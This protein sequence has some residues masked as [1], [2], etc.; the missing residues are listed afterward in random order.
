MVA[1]EDR[2]VW[3][4]VLLYP[5]VS[6]Y[7][8]VVAD[9]DWA[10]QFGARANDDV[11]ADRRVPPV[12]SLFQCPCR[13]VDLEMQCPQR[14]V[15]VQPAPATKHCCLANDSANAVVNKEVLSDLSTR[16]EVDGSEPVCQLA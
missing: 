6:S 2:R 1:Y 7:A 10:K 13:L 15:L 9:R 3:R 11:A 8:H 12:G 5:A 16:M 14:H 4:N